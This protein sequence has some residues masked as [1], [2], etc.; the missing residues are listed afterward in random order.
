MLYG[1]FLK[2]SQSFITVGDRFI[3]VGDQALRFQSVR[4][5]LLLLDWCGKI[6]SYL[7]FFQTC[8]IFLEVMAGLYT[9]ET[10]QPLNKTQVIKAFLKNQEQTNNTIN[11]LAEEI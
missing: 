7:I 2:V 4:M 6:N 8:N 5:Y 11:T 10:L 1:M 9:E 3:T